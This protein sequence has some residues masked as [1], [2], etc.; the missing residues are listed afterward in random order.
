MKVGL[1]VDI[2]QGSFNDICHKA[3]EAEQAGLDGV[4]CYDHLWPIGHPGM[5]AMSCFP[6]LGALAASTR[7]ISVGTLVARVGLYGNNMLVHSFEALNVIA[8]GRV[9]AGIGTGDSRSLQEDDAYG[10]GCL[11]AHERRMLV[12]ECARRLVNENIE[13]WIGSGSSQRS[14]SS[15][16]AVAREAGAAVNL[17]QADLTITRE[18]VS[19][20]LPVTWAGSLE[21]LSADMQIS[22]AEALSALAGSGVRWAVFSGNGELSARSLYAKLGKCI[23]ERR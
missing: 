11:Y 16:I 17:W 2:F 4:F 22:D 14:M 13:A 20:G 19:N 3:Q 10:V 12:A 6:V 23:Q 18:I 7:R 9:I 8:P 1:I 21:R 15:S 5:P